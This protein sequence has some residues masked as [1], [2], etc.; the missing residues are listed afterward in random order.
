MS[1]FIKTFRHAFHNL[2][3]SCFH[4]TSRLTKSHAA[5]HSH[6]SQSSNFGSIKTGRGDFNVVSINATSRL[7]ASP[8]FARLRRGAS[9]AT[10][11][12]CLR[13]RELQFHL[14]Q[15]D[16]SLYHRVPAIPK[17]TGSTPAKFEAVRGRSSNGA[18][19]H[20]H[21]TPGVTF[22]CTTIATSA[23]HFESPAGAF[24]N[25]RSLRAPGRAP[26]WMAG[27]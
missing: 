13:L 10:G 21:G 12:D 15:Y 18:T 2:L 17:H 24:T 25:R 1:V 23:S 4:H 20:L 7:S 3:P 8:W 9:T 5:T 6:H 19:H 22:A 14:L 27:Q 16:R 26:W 11:R